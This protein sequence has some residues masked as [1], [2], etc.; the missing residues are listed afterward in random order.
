MESDPEY[1]LC[2][3]LINAI[4]VSI[5][6]YLR[7]PVVAVNYTEKLKG[8]GTKYLE[9]PMYPVQS[10]T[11]MNVLTTY[12]RLQSEDLT[13]D[14]D[15]FLDKPSGMIE[16]D[17]YNGKLTYFPKIPKGITV[18][19]SAGVAADVASIPDDIKLAA[20]MLVKFYWSKDI[21]DFSTTFQ[22]TGAIIRPESFPAQVRVILG[23]YQKPLRIGAV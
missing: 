5:D 16:L 21:A 14:V 1:D 3:Q 4:T 8:D 10:I 18:N 22:D 9:L 11:S 6:K 17:I 13:E 15:Y 2:Q 12:D 7:R 20:K 23:P 19:Y